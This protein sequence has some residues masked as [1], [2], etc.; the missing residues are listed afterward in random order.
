[1]GSH[2]YASFKPASSVVKSDKDVQ[3]WISE[4]DVKAQLD[5][6]C[7]LM[8]SAGDGGHERV[9]CDHAVKLANHPDSCLR[10]LKYAMHTC[11][12]NTTLT[13][14]LFK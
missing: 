14:A 11:S 9:L 4:E 6:K 12:G 3:E 1:M 10:N 13:V 5:L 7:I 2:A 8:L